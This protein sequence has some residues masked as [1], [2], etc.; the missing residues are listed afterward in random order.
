MNVRGRHGVK[1]AVGRTGGE[2][3]SRSAQGTVRAASNSTRLYA[4]WGNQSRGGT[5]TFS[6]AYIRALIRI[7]FL[8][9]FFAIYL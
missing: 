2:V 6:A 4:E 7:L 1:E 8:I 5:H 3:V 9:I